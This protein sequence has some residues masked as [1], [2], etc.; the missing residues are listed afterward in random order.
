MKSGFVRPVLFAVALLAVFGGIWL[1]NS[2]NTW[3]PGQSRGEHE[4][5]AIHLVL[6]GGSVTAVGVVGVLTL[7]LMWLRQ[8][9]QDRRR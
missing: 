7:I 9:S 5:A 1:I 8:R 4:D 6:I 2:A 3:I